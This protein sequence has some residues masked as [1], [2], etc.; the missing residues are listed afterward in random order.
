MEASRLIDSGMIAIVSGP[1]ACSG[2]EAAG[3]C[4]AGRSS[5]ARGSDSRLIRDGLNS[6]A[7]GRRDISGRSVRDGAFVFGAASLG[8]SSKELLTTEV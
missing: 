6:L 1:S 7:G 3:R 4:D 2:R 5:S 8:S